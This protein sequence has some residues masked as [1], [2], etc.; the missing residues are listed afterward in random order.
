[1]YHTNIDTSTDWLIFKHCS[2]LLGIL[3]L[4]FSHIHFL[5]SFLLSMAWYY[6]TTIIANTNEPMSKSIL[7]YYHSYVSLKLAPLTLTSQLNHVDKNQAHASVLGRRPP[8]G[9]NKRTAYHNQ[10]GAVRTISTRD[11]LQRKLR[12]VGV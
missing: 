2:K 7:Q 1:M 6:P 12:Y 8:F 10:S 3:T 11:V 5:E 9:P 4:R